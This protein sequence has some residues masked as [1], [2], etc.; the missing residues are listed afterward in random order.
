MKQMLV[1]AYL[2]SVARSTNMKRLLS[3]CPVAFVALL[4]W[5]VASTQTLAQNSAQP[6]Q[7]QSIPPDSPRWELQ[8]QAKATEYQGRKCLYLDGGAATLKEL[9]LR[10]GVID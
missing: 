5:L 6:S 10:D 8:G 4:L 2:C 7:T 9:E 1:P 3:T